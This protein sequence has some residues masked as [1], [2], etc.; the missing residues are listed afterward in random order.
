METGK[1]STRTMITKELQETFNLA[2]NEAVT[3]RHEYITLEHLLYALLHDH[4]ASEVIRHCG[5]DVNKLGKELESFFEEHL[6]TIPEDEEEMPTQTVALQRVLEYAV[7]EAQGSGQKEIDG[8]NILAAL[9][10][11]E[12]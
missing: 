1:R 9:F 10:R 11:E 12:K 8:G 4:T 7:L 5:G 2:V 6:T 3:R